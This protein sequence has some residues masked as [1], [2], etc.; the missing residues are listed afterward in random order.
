MNNKKWQDQ[1]NRNNIFFEEIFPSSPTH[2][3]TSMT[4]SNFWVG[5]KFLEGLETQKFL[6]PIFFKK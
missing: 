6:G 1:K 4:W 3:F 2:E 5:P